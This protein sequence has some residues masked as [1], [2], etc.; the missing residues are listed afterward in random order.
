MSILRRG[1]LVKL[2]ITIPAYNEEN[3]ISNVLKEIPRKIDGIDTI[4]VL[5]IDDGSTDNT[6]KKAVENGVDEVIVHK[7]NKGLGASFK[8]GIDS[9]LEKVAD[10]IVN[11]DADG[12]YNATQISDLIQPILDGKADIV[13][14]WR[15]INNLSHMPKSK[16]LGNRL[17]SWITRRLSGLPLKDA[18]TGFRAFSKE[19][20]IRLNLYG[21]YTYTQ[22]TLIQASY[23]GLQIEQIPVEFRARDGKSRLISNISTY[24]FRAGATVFSTYRDYY[25]LKLF[26]LIGGT[27]TIIGLAFGILVLVHFYHTGMVSPHLPTAILAT[28]LIIIGLGTFALGIFVHMLNTQRRLSEEILYRLKKN[29]SNNGSLHLTKVHA[30]QGKGGKSND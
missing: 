2:V 12:Q 22:E 5:L 14:G 3:T 17:A 9:A 4:E 26:S 15:D 16:K 21:K 6:V 23:K 30:L 20:A 27:I 18:Q 1:L 8:D 7:V 10:I 28:L 25:P 19:A 29:G 13:L 11:I 24:A